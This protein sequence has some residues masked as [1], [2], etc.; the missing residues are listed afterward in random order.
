MV[1]VANH[2]VR[3]LRERCQR[4]RV[5]D[6]VRND[7]A[8]LKASRVIFRDRNVLEKRDIVVISRRN[9]SVVERR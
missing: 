9:E 2:L 1:D 5:K 8:M 4:N 3:A 7:G 6:F